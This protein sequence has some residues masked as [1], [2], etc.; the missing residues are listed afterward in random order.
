MFYEDGSF[1]E[2]VE[3]VDSFE[4]PVEERDDV[5]EIAYDLG[6]AV[7]AQWRSIMGDTPI[8][9]QT[10]VQVFKAGLQRK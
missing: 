10:L 3:G 8:D 4:R 7:E 1:M 6:Y 2:I 5:F 9:L